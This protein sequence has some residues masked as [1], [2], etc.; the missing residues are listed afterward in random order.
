MQA[1]ARVRGLSSYHSYSNACEVYLSKLRG[2]PHDGSPRAGRYLSQRCSLLFL[3]NSTNICPAPLYTPPKKKACLPQ[4]ISLRV[5]AYYSI[6]NTTNH[7]A[8]SVA[9]KIFLNVLHIKLRV[10][11]DLDQSIQVVVTLSGSKQK[12]MALTYLPLQV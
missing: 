11:G 8:R 9:P 5:V 7:P 4:S 10:R 1:E 12:Q 6:R 3:D 2:A